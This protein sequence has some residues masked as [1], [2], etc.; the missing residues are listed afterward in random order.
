MNLNDAIKQRITNICKEKNITLN[1]LATLSRNNSI[2]TRK[3]YGW[4]YKIPNSNYHFI[5][6]SRCTD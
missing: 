1:K 6:M 2:D 5:Y 3:Y 4:K